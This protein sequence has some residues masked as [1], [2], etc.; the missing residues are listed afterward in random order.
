MDSAALFPELARVDSSAG[1]PLTRIGS[2]S[3]EIDWK[4]RWQ[5]RAVR[6][7]LGSAGI[8]FVAT[9]G[10]TLLRVELRLRA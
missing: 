4:P 3:L 10:A 7:I 5:G 2:S 6:T 8:F 1:L 9:T